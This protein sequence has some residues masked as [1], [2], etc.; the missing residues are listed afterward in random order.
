MPDLSLVLGTKGNVDSFDGA[1]R[2]AG[3][4]SAGSFRALACLCPRRQVR[5]GCRACPEAP[6]PRPAP[7]PARPARPH[8]GAGPP[9]RLQ[10]ARADTKARQL[11]EGERP[12]PPR[13][14]PYP[15]APPPAA[16]AA[17]PDR[18]AP[19]RGRHGC[20]GSSSRG[21]C[22]RSGTRRP[23]R[24]HPSQCCRK[25]NP[26]PPSDPD[27]ARQGVRAHAA[28][29]RRALRQQ[30]ERGTLAPALQFARGV[31]EGEVVDRRP[32]LPPGCPLPA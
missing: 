4:S 5:P 27:S 21:R 12:R 31:R 13:A 24:P 7:R 28:G 19:P 9:P 15:A 8:R 17:V 2:R 25:P 18:R 1:R 32:L 16:P 11:A 3:T 22:R 29:R 6:P 26:G 14:R 23:Y 30:P 20:Y 10:P